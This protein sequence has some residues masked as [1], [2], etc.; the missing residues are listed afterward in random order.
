VILEHRESDTIQRLKLVN[1]KVVIS[2]KIR[3]LAYYNLDDTDEEF[4]DIEIKPGTLFIPQISF[5]LPMPNYLF[6]LLKNTNSVYIFNPFTMDK[7][8]KIRY[9]TGFMAVNSSIAV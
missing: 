2:T 5:I 7:I 3:P 1:T 6:V 8:T 9:Q 4:L